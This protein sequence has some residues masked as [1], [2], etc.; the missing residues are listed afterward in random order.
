MILHKKTILLKIQ[1]TESN[2]QDGETYFRKNYIMEE[3]EEEKRNM[4]LK[5]ETTVF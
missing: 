1:Q 2:C 5:I 3:E 4:K